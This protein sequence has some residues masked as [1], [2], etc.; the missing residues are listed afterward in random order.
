MGTF[1]KVLKAGAIMGVVGLLLAASA[2]LIA[3]VLGKSILGAAGVAAAEN[4][5]ATVA[6]SGAFFGAFGAINA[7]V[8]PMFDKLFGAS[9]PANAPA[10]AKAPTPE[11]LRAKAPELVQ[12]EEKPS[13][14]HQDMEDKRRAA[15]AVAAV[16][17]PAQPAFK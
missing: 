16:M 1:G 2:P 4:T 13:R 8:A 6:W 14:Y 10:E 5:F 17:K 11:P 12:A 3:G 9:E 7:M 15:A